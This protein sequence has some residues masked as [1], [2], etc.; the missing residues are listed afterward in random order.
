MRLESIGGQILKK[1]GVR[2]FTTLYL[3]A[4]GRMISDSDEGRDRREVTVSVVM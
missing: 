3:F 1:N 4:L 2:L